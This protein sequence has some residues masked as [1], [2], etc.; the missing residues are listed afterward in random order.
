MSQ[1]CKLNLSMENKD[2]LASSPV[3]SCSDENDLTKLTQL[4]SELKDL[5]AKIV[6][7]E[8]EINKEKNKLTTSNLSIQRHGLK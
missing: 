2:S 8:I 1:T 3:S 7:L 4:E 6:K 5:N